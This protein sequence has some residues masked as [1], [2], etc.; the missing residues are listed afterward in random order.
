[1]MMNDEKTHAI[2]ETKKYKEH[3]VKVISVTD[4]LVKYDVT[5]EKHK[6]AVS[7]YCETALFDKCLKQMLNNCSEYVYLLSLFC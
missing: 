4:V 5:D 2:N 3:F 6:K 1:M 7:N